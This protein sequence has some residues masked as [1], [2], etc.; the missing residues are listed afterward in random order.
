M[1]NFNEVTIKSSRSFLIMSIIYTICL[2][3][4][5]VLTFIDGGDLPNTILL[6]II[7][8]GVIDNF[9]LSK[10]NVRITS[11][12]ICVNSLFKKQFFNYNDIEITFGERNFGL[13]VSKVCKILVK[14][15]NKNIVLGTNH[16][17]KIIEEMK[18]LNL[19][20]NN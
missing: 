2:I 4:I 20:E 6:L 9:I 16:Y 3:V 8:F 13:Q 10:R 5:F 11:E 15:S 17:P 12:G 1:N 7:F 19:D 14:E 18:K